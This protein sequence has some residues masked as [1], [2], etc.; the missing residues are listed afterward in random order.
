MQRTTFIVIAILGAVL[1]AL[2]SV[3][4]LAQ[5][6]RDT[7]KN[8]DQVLK[9]NARVN[10]STLAMEMSVPLGTYQGRAGNALS[11]T[12]NYSSKLW[13]FREFGTVVNP[14]G[15]EG[16]SVVPLYARGTAAGWT[17]GLAVPRIEILGGSDIPYYMVG[18]GAEYEGAIW[19]NIFYGEG[20]NFDI[21][22]MKRLHV[23]L[24]GGSTHEF[25]AN[26]S[27]IV[28]GNAYFTCNDVDFTGTYLSV[29][30]SK[31]RLEFGSSGSTLFMSDGSRI[32]FDSYGYAT[33]IIDSHGNKTTYNSTTKQWTDTMGRALPNPLPENPT[34]FGWQNHHQEQTVGDQAISTPGMGTETVETTLSWRY[35]KHP[36]SSD[37][38]DSG[39]GNTSQDLAYATDF[40]CVGSLYAQFSE[41]K[42]FFN[43]NAANVRLCNYDGTGLPPGIPFNPIVLT[44]I[45]LANGQSY[46]FKYNVYGEVEKIIYPSGGY[47]RFVHANI[48]GLQVT[49]GPY[50]QLNRGV[51]DRY[52]SAK[53]DGTDEVHWSYSAVRNYVN[54]IPQPYTVT[55]TNPDGTKTVK[56]LHDEPEYWT[57]RP[58]GFDN[59]RTGRPYEEQT[60]SSDST[61]ALLARTLT[62]YES[63]GPL[64]GGYEVATRDVRPVKEISITFEPGSSSALAT[65]TETVYDATGHPDPAYFAAT[66]PKQVK[67]Y[68][69]V[70]VTASTAATASVTT[71]AGWFSSGNLATVMEMDYLYDSNYKARNINGLVTETRIKDAGGNVK[72]KTQITYDESAYKLS[73]SGTMPAAAANS[74]T[75]PLTELG[76]TLGAKRGQPTT[77]KNYH[78]IANGLYVETHNFYDQFGNVRKV[79]DGRGNDTET[80]YDDDY[81]FAYPT[82]VITPVPD[83]T[84]TQG[85]SS[86]FESTN[87]Y[88]YTTGLPL[89]T[90][91][92][93]G[94]VT[95]IEYNDP[96]L[97]PTKTIAPNTAETLTEYGAG[98]TAS[99]RWVKVKTQIDATNWKEA[100]SWFDGLG[101]TIKTQ[102]VDA[103]TGDVFVETEY[104]NMGRVKK[105][106]N[107]YRAGY[108]IFWTENTFDSAGRPWKITTPDGAVVETTY[109]LATAG[110]CLGTTVTVEDQADKFRRSITNGLGQL[111]RIDEPNGG[112][113]LGTVVSPNQATSYTYDTLGNLTEIV[114]G[115]QTRTFIYN[116]LS[117][118]LSGTNPES[119]TF[120]YTYD[121]NGNLLTKIDARNIA[122]THTYDA[123]NRVTAKNYSDSSPDI[124]YTY[125]DSQV[126]FSKG[127]LTK[128]AS[129]VSETHYS[130]YDEQERITESKQVTGGQTYTFGYTYNLDDDLTTQIYPSGKVVSFDYDASGDLEQVHKQVGGNSVIYANSFAYSPHGQIEKL[131]FGNH[132]W[133]TTEFNSNRQITQVGLGNSATDTGQWRVNYEYG[134]LQTNGTVDSTKNNGNLAKQ[135]IDVP[136]IGTVA[137]FTATQSY[138]YDALDRLKSAAETIGGNQTWKQTFIY[139]R[140]GNKNF[141]TGNTTIQSNESAIPK[142]VN[143]EILTS[144]NRFKEDQDGDSQP[145]Y[146]YDASGNLF[147]NAQERQFTFNAENLQV[148]ASGT[149]LSVSY[150]YDGNNK[151]VTSYNSVTDQTTIFVYDADGDLAAE[152]TI[153]V[154]PPA[155][156]TITYLTE[157]A[158]G[159]IR[160]TTNALGELK[161]RRDF[162]PFGEELYAG[163]A[164][165]NTDQRYSS[166][167]DDTRKKFAT[168]QRDT[169]TGLD[170]AQS[171]YFSAMHGRFTSPD[172]FKGGP[173][174]LFDFE[175]AASSNPT[176]YADLENPQSL[177]KYQYSYN[178]PY[179]FNDPTGH[180]PPCA[181]TLPWVIPA[182]GDLILTGIT[183]VVG[184]GAA[185]SIRRAYRTPDANLGGGDCM[186]CDRNLRANQ[187]AAE[188]RFENRA[189]P[190]EP[191]QP[192]GQGQANGEV[193]LRGSRN[194]KVAKAAAEGRRQ[195]KAFAD[196]VKK[197]QG[198]TSEKKVTNAKTGESARP[199]ARTPGGNPIELKPNTPSG[200]RKGAEQRKTQERVTEKRGRVVYYEPKP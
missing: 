86:A 59:V 176:F 105:V 130:E 68:N 3:G 104:D 15:S 50:E 49:S 124:T 99:T 78:D 121:P 134:E 66:N 53:G 21:K 138:T 155:T 131:R 183:V 162:L 119:G 163:L 80:L 165:R 30:G 168:Y 46:Q 33:A 64:S 27:P 9:S 37:P 43:N 174:E 6:K 108:T 103:S 81:A 51:T 65:M 126:P 42:L 128:V 87:T 10:P 152:Y 98:T 5:G 14:S 170:F 25:R 102:S 184:A 93:N 158:L 115:G 116:S 41:A 95:Q 70:V 122:T 127:K 161:A 34:K 97:R 35:L 166:S 74:W 177:N 156:P 179:K 32:L 188:Q 18:C 187:R 133:E 200:R 181:A 144:N 171:R 107:P 36:T 4:A 85:S 60:Y 190:V 12:L 29:D 91:D 71:A 58:F 52:V 24:P 109:G 150:G 136:T 120:T 17:S 147:K 192:N 100:Y 83:S 111:C 8:P 143:P 106:T 195:H 88:D 140:F 117:R 180:C 38:D 146:L 169:D 198:W 123:L 193:K 75:D 149:G 54:F 167:T 191:R 31:M 2:F 92:P 118:L 89:T 172:E 72:A 148:A 48:Y 157:D 186:S 151:R 110:N 194:P 197:K 76:P 56:L 40:Y 125:D 164:G 44:K 189:S 139:D 84:G 20:C 61:P 13:E 175:E 101:R 154:P 22:Y 94:G 196:K 67:K 145:D 7:D 159:N 55:T 96:L 160:V 82:K 129:S 23:V 63:T 112:N 19:S 26:D 11:N 178:N 142:V 135:T 62:S 77:V 185:E 132:K 1:F 137:G 173:D 47:E 153:N 57:Q 90:T 28:C 199:D 39:L 114:Q 79:R 113:E 16:I 69:Y 182:A 45:T 141:D 73:S